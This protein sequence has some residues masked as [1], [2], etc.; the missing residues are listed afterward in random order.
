MLLAQGVN[1]N[2][3]QITGPLSGI[4]TLADL[5]NKVTSFIIPVAAIILL[6]VLIW[7]GY[8]FMMSGGAPEKVKGAQAKIT[9]GIIGFVLL[10]CSFIIVKLIALIF[11]FGGGIF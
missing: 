8:D 2:G 7:G 10:I 5:V 9:T 3:Q 11:G 1:I 6:F 4:T